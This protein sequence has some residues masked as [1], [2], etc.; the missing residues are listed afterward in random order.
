MQVSGAERSGA[1]MR[2]RVAGISVA[3]AVLSGLL[4]VR[5]LAAES[6][7]PAVIR[8]APF[9]P[10]LQEVLRVESDG[11]FYAQATVNGVPLRMLFDTG[12]S[13]V[14]IRAEDAPRLGIDPGQLD[15][16]IVTHTANGTA[17]AAPVIVAAVT[18]GGIT[19]RDVSAIV[20][21][22]GQLAENLLGQSFL[23]R[24][25]GYRQQGNRLVLLDTQ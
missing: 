21:R 3:L 16:R 7:L 9:Q 15:Y 4:P 25:P 12:A 17:R 18:I 6:V 23:T 11:H 2:E 5:P 13:T 14:V 24:L 8:P 20:A 22:P 19:R 1:G 10:G